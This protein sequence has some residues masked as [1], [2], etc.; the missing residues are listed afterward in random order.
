[1]SNIITSAYFD[2]NQ[3]KVVY[4]LQSEFNGFIGE[5]VSISDTFSRKRLYTVID[6]MLDSNSATD[7]NFDAKKTEQSQYHDA[8]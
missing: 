7:P 4:T 6:S 5:A 1:M 2:Y 3:G 8:M